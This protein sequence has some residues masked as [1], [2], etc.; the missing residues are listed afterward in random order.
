MP[1]PEVVRSRPDP[2]AEVC[3]AFSVQQRQNAA[4]NLLDPQDA[5]LQPSLRRGAKVL[6][7]KAPP[8]MGNLAAMAAWES[9]Q[10][11]AAE[12]VDASSAFRQ[13]RQQQ[14]HHAGAAAGLRHCGSESSS[15]GS[16]EGWRQSSVQRRGA[17]APKVA[18]E[19]EDVLKLPFLPKVASL[20]P[21][22]VGSMREVYGKKEAFK[23]QMRDRGYP[24]PAS[25]KSGGGSGPGSA[26]SL[27]EKPAKEGLKVCRSGPGSARSISKEKMHSIGL[28]PQ[29]PPSARSLQ[30]KG[31]STAPVEILRRSNSAADCCS[32]VVTASGLDLPRRPGSDRG[33]REGLGGSLGSSRSAGCLVR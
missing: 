2:E 28:L 9:R 33:R 23:L 10:F 20:P 5:W 19:P 25:V 15:F 6:P 7:P 4:P 11:A 12:A 26:R 8:T 27:S 14:H 17:S 13:Q 30:G 29:L 21:K 31:A 24:A 22:K 16:E 32:N 1:E 3:R 18:D